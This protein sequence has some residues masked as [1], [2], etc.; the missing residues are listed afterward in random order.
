EPLLD[1]AQRQ[2]DRLL[3]DLP[4]QPIRSNWDALELLENLA[5]NAPVRL[6]V[7]MAELLAME[8]RIFPFGR[9]CYV[10]VCNEQRFW[11]LLRAS[12]E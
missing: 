11:N 4:A 7:L 6:E 10:S 12:Y 8:R 2:V 5:V 1:I 3:Q 9:Y